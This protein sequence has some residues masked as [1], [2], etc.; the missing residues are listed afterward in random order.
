MCIYQLLC[1]PQEACVLWAM[2]AD[3]AL[4]LGVCVHN[5]RVR[6]ITAVWPPSPPRWYKHSYMNAN[7]MYNISTCHTYNCVFVCVCIV[8][9]VFKRHI[10]TKQWNRISETCSLGCLHTVFSSV[11]RSFIHKIRQSF[12]PLPGNRMN[13]R[14]RFFF[15]G[16]MGLLGGFVCSIGNGVPMMWNA[17]ECLLV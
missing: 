2:Q 5:T 1:T 4:E 8:K 6:N 7:R 11:V 17:C 9:R 12:F 13:V 10:T 16:G 3:R 14:R 15:R